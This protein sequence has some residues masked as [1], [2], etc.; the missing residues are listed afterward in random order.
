MADAGPSERPTT[1]PP[2]ASTS[3]EGPLTPEQVKRV[4]INRLKG[5]LAQFSLA[6][7]CINSD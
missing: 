2:R 5:M 3:I 4:E 7:M 6:V 1:P